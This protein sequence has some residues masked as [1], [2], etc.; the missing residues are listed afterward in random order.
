MPIEFRCTQ[1][2]KLLRTA[3]DTWGKKAKCPEC[4]AVM[5][6]PETPHA[7]S[8]GGDEPRPSSS[9]D[10]GNPYQSPS[11]FAPALPISQG[12]LDLGD[13]LNRTW[14]LF[15]ADMGECVL[16]ALIVML[17]NIGVSSAS[18]FV[19]VVGTIVS[20]LFSV[21]IHIGLALYFLK[22]A[23]GQE[24]LIGEVFN[25][26]PHFG[27]ILLAVLLVFLIM[28]G[29]VLVCVLPLLLVGA[30]ISK[31]AAV[32]FAAVG[33]VAATGLIWYIMLAFSQF[34]YLILDRNIDVIL[35]MKTSLSLMEG[36]KL[37]LF[38]IQLVAGVLGSVLT[39]LTCGL[40]LFFVPPFLAMMQAVIYL[41]IT[42]QPT[43]EQ[44]NPEVAL[45]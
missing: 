45:R 44:I 23:R 33:F 28:A 32:G 2:Q 9:V 11:E 14:V 5:T 22:K 40:G 12:T 25:G 27:K 35:A 38:I 15:N 8:L 30:T 21:W 3:D 41:T 36:N 34:Y 18:F 19:P 13:I 16:A 26:W 17:L 42:G 7:D 31:E 39:L 43:A 20:T 6:I 4:G 10:S 37:M 29:I 1:C 24:V